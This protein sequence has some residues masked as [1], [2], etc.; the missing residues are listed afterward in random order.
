MKLFKPLA[1]ILA[2]VFIIT[3][4]TGYALN[5]QVILTIDSNVEDKWYKTKSETIPRFSTSSQVVKKQLFSVLV[6]FTGYTPDNEN[7]V[8]IVYDIE[9]LT[10]DKKSYFKQENINAFDSTVQSNK[11]VLM[12]KDYARI[13]F[14][15][16]DQF[17]EYTFIINSKDAVTNTSAESKT[18]IILHEY[19]KEIYFNNADQLN[20]WV[21]GYHEAPSPEKAINGFH[22]CIRNN[23]FTE[24]SMAPLYSFFITIFKDNQF[25]I[26][27]LIDEFNMSDPRTRMYML[28]LF[29][30]LQYNFDSF[31]KALPDD[32]K[33]IYLS[34]TE[35]R[36]PDPYSTITDA[37]QLDMLWGITL[38][39]GRYDTVKKIVETLDYKMFEGID[40]MKFLIYGAA[41]W[42][43]KSNCTRHTLVKDYCRYMLENE[44]LSET[45]RSE[46]TEILI[47]E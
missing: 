13:C 24:N 17:G 41:K 32:E 12:C 33:D 15:P 22:F 31:I 30:H 47:E 19:R 34:A 3:A 28:F 14:E 23:L 40:K 27:Y 16:E 46:L 43:L 35:N 20:E 45:V 26:P 8:H 4:K 5:S 37:S 29:A 1:L 44:P 7:K 25:L 42:S 38:S 11:L 36:L 2:A 6:F 9:I 18:V 10:P 39:T 21:T